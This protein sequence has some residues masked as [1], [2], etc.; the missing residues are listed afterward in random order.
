MRGGRRWAVG[1]LSR[2]ISLAAPVRTMLATAGVPGRTEERSSGTPPQPFPRLRSRT[3]RP[4]AGRTPPPPQPRS[5][6]SLLASWAAARSRARPT[7]KPSTSRQHRRDRLP[8]PPPRPPAVAPDGSDRNPARSG[9]RPQGALP[10]HTATCRASDGSRFVRASN[11]RSRVRVSRRRARRRCPGNGDP[12]A[13]YRPTAAVDDER[14]PLPA[15]WVGCRSEA[16]AKARTSSAITTACR[17]MRASAAGRRDARVHAK[18]GVEA[19]VAD[20]PF[21]LS[22]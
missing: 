17:P 12:R 18:A 21:L 4:P 15:G 20:T 5:A 13:V 1:S 6:R 9:G 19:V 11:A 10:M 2:T 8:D 7:T 22:E 16:I 3:D 14:H